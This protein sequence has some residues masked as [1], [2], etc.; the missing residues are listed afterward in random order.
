MEYDRLFAHMRKVARDSGVERVFRTH[1]VNVIIGPADGF[2]STMASSGGECHI[3]N[4]GQWMR[5]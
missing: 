3:T 5:N 4:P 1:G 2:I